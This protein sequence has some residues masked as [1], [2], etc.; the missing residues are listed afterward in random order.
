MSELDEK[1]KRLQEARKKA[2]DVA[3]RRQRI[4]GELDGH[5]K[6]SAELEK[7]CRED[8]GCEVDEL[9]SLSTRLEKEAEKSIAEAE[10]LLTVPA[11]QAVSVKPAVTPAKPADS[12]KATPKRV[13]VSHPDDEDV[14]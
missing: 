13:P 11:I 5:L 9:P 6:R 2:E 14:L 3:R 8:Y 1:M 10:H 7:K 12:Q 4:A